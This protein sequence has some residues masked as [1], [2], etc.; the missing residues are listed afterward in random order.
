VKHCIKS[1]WERQIV[2]V[3][4]DEVCDICK[5]MVGQARDTLMSNETQEELKE[6]FDGSCDLIPIKV[7]SKECRTL[8]EE[9]V[10]EL[11]ETLAS[12]MNPD[13]VCTVAGLC[14]SARIDKLLEKQNSVVGA[15]C[16]QCEAQTSLIQQRLT[17]MPDFQ[18]EMKLLELCG[19]LGSY[20]DSCMYTVSTEIQNIAT[21]LRTVSLS[22][23]CQDEGTCV[24]TVDES[25]TD[26]LQCEFCSKVVKH[27]IDVYA[28]NSSLEEFKEI[29]DGIC[30][31]VDKK[32]AEHCK[33]IVDDYYMPMFEFLRTL[34]PHMVCSFVGLCG[35]QD[36]MEVGRSVPITTLLAPK[37]VVP[38]VPLIK[39]EKSVYI[40]EKPTCVLCEF[41]MQKLEYYLKDGQT[42][43]QIKE[44]V[45]HICQ[46]MP[47][48]VRSKCKQFV[49]TY[50]PLLIQLLVSE[51]DPSMICK[52]INLCDKKSVYQAAV[53]KSSTCETCQFVMD[54]VFSVLSDKDDQ[55][56]VV[57]VLESICY[58]LPASIDQ[59]C[60]QFVDKYT[61][62]ILDM[63]STSL[64]PA[65][66]CSG[67]DLCDD[68]EEIDVNPPTPP[69]NLQ[70]TGCVLCEYVISNL[71]KM[72]KDK[73]NEEEIKQALENVCSYM[74]GNIKDQCDQFVETYTDLVIQ[75]LTGEVSPEEVCGYLGLCK[76]ADLTA[77]ATPDWSRGPYCTLCEYAISAVDNML[78]DSKTEQEIIQALD[79]VCYHL[80]APVHKECLKMVEKYTDEIIHMLAN[81]YTP[82]D[83][84][85]SISL[86]VNS[87][88]SSNQIG[89]LD[90][91][92]AEVK[93]EEEQDENV[94]CIMC[95]FAMEVIDE[96]IDDASTVD[97]IERVVQF[98]CSYLPGSIADKCQDFVDQN[99]Q[100]IIDSLVKG[101]LEP[102]EVCTLQLNLCSGAG[103]SDRDVLG[104]GCDFGP[105][106]WCASPFH[107]RLCNAEKY[108]QMTAWN[109]GLAVNDL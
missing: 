70:D 22:P 95:E 108:C 106:L 96:H 52:E 76:Q 14:N 98:L 99:G 77:L 55:D 83:V 62:M 87:E 75:L 60:E 100:K 93:D 9:F 65:E 29:L 74:P 61:S 41:V 47:S 49:D 27:W 58:R 71:D 5:N 78:Q 37:K 48:T 88:I 30:D 59:P 36:F 39:A 13:T 25:A 90:D 64:T 81:N 97:Q 103:Q 24:S 4:T 57:N 66:V 32:H 104:G 51:M 26:D 11:V 16:N 105:D 15:G 102:K 73:T 43:E 10:P 21:Y 91:F 84:C 54:E 68:K 40:T 56:M 6:V 63:I 42:E 34:D 31:Q 8:A 12:E 94:A 109:L 28:S 19:Y 85:S 89:S 46:E 45:E 33:H 92:Y 72:L 50:E 101:E 1:V 80:T 38:M 69:A 44:Y 23:L 79:V 7:V 53:S 18:I 86:C 107:A 82:E 67:L 35:N 20:S 17:T 2:P 3:D